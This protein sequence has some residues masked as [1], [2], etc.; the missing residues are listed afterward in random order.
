M[1]VQLALVGV[2]AGYGR[3]EVLH[4]VDLALPAG[5]IV[6]LAGRN[7][8][9]KSSI[10]R[11]IAGTLRAR[12]GQIVWFGTDVSRLSA[13]ERARRGMVFVPDEGAVF[14]ELTVAENLRLFAG[15]AAIAPLLATFPE[16]DPLLDR[17]AGVLS[18][19]ERQMLALSRALLRPGAV[20]LLDEVTRGLAPPAVA[21]LHDAIRSLVSPERTVVVVEQSLQDALDLA[22]IVYVV[23]RGEVSFAGEPNE[24]VASVRDSVLG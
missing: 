10:L 21:R 9:G 18:G 8:A 20:T 22:D 11:T 5:A 16:L 6:A 7:A 4:G 23:R 19:G 17:A 2:R 14:T 15:R 3:V 1:S 12:S 24:L 13:A